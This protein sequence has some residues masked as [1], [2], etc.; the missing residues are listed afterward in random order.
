MKPC[1]EGFILC[2]VVRLKYKFLYKNKEKSLYKGLFFVSTNVDY[3]G[4]GDRVRVSCGHL[5]AQHRS[6]DRGGSRELELAASSLLWCPK[7]LFGLE[8]R[9]ILTAAPFSPRFIVHRTR[10][11]D[12]A[13][14]RRACFARRNKK[15]VTFQLLLIYGRGDR[16]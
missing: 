6:T 1:A 13:Q 10:F 4:Q 12:N 14:S 7:S 2:L 8:R 16:T 11:R 3:Y 5:C 9:A 15:T